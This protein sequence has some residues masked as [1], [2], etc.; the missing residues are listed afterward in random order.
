MKSEDL[1]GLFMVL[2]PFSLAA[3]GGGPSIFGPLQHETVDVRHWLSARDFIDLFAVARAAPGPATM[4]A[5]LIGWRVAGLVGA[6][7]GTI[8]IF[9]PSSLLCFGVAKVW[10]AYRGRL[11]HS[12]LEDGLAPVAAGLVFAGAVNIFQIANAGLVG[13]GVALAA[14]LALA[15]WPKLHPFLPLAAG[16]LVFVCAVLVR[17]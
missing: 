7:V 3:I 11:W 13:A 12:A 1:L 6:L 5:A 14:M 10:N 2:A 16:A 15:I 4:I 17:G 8:S 9:L